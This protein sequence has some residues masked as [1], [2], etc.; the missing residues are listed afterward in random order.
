MDAG[1][2]KVVAAETV[3]SDVQGAEGRLI[4]RGVDVE[5]LAQA[6]SYEQTAAHL[7]AGYVDHMPDDLQPMLGAAR[8]AAFARL[9]EDFSR[10]AA[11]PLRL[12]PH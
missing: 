12:M 7:W 9:T 11:L 8:V 5:Q 1:L 6:F 3:M 2:E 10:L 4:I